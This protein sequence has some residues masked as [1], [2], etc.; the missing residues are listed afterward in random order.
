M[1]P[2][3]YFTFF[4]GCLTVC[5]AGALQYKPPTR[6]CPACGLVTPLSG[7]GC[8]RHCGYGFA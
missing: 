3:L 8:C 1:D 6:P 5:V 4:I 7:A 2:M